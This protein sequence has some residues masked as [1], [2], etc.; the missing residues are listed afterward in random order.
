[1]RGR[2]VSIGVFFWEIFRLA[3]LRRHKCPKSISLNT[4]FR[5]SSIQ[6]ATFAFIFS[7]GARHLFP[8]INIGL[9]KR[10]HFRSFSQ[11]KKTENAVLFCAW[12]YQRKVLQL[13][14][15]CQAPFLLTVFPH[16][17]F[18]KNA[19]CRLL[20]HNNGIMPVVGGCAPG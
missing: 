7:Y 6:T 10:L 16:H 3:A 2:G 19:I 11:Q 14:R 5:K 4:C 17:C 13:L 12:R 15:W 8:S 1:M 9:S 18:P 20:P